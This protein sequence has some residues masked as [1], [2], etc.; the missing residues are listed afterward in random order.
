MR[1]YNINSKNVSLINLKT[2]YLPNDKAATNIEKLFPIPLP[3]MGV[4]LELIC[5]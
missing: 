5:I 4:P 2:I 3:S 1:V